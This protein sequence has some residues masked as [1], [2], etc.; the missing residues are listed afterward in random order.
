MSST[1]PALSVWSPLDAQTFLSRLLTHRAEQ[2]QEAGW[3][4]L[5]L[6][7]AFFPASSHS[8]EFSFFPDSFRAN[9][10]KNEKKEKEEG[11]RGEER[12][13]E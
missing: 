1:S 5:L 12:A 2:A 9:C 8:W 6:T 7:G 13:R 11:E 3:L 10:R 4:L